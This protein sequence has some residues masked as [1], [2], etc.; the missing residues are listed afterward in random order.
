MF[1]FQLRRTVFDKFSSLM[2]SQHTSNHLIWRTKE[3][4]LRR[5]LM[6]ASS[7]ASKLRLLPSA[8]KILLRQKPVNAQIRTQIIIVIIRALPTTTTAYTEWDLSL[9][10]VKT[11]LFNPVKFRIFICLRVANPH[12]HRHTHTHNHTHTRYGHHHQQLWRC[13]ENCS[14]SFTKSS[15]MICMYK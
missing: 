14:D 15:I 2:Y 10:V 11:W 9:I 1:F 8:V 4:W 13:F 7:T 3:W 12:H 5:I 6:T